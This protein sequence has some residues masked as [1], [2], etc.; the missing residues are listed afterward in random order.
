M[1]GEEAGVISLK[2][3]ALCIECKRTGPKPFSTYLKAVLHLKS[4]VQQAF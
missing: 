3:S 4:S 2:D 1:L